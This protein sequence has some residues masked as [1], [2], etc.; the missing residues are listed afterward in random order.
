MPS[1]PPSCPPPTLYWCFTHR[2]LH[3][4]Q[5]LGSRERQRMLP[6]N[7]PS[8][9]PAS[10]SSVIVFGLLP[11]TWHPTLKAVPRTSF[12]VPFSSLEKDLYR[13]VLAISTISSRV[14][15]LLCLMFFSFFR[16][17]GGSFNAL[18]MRDDAVGTTET[19]ACRFWI[20]N[21]TVTRSPFCASHLVSRRPERGSRKSPSIPSRPSPSRY[22][23][24]LSSAT[25]REDRSWGREPTT[26]QPHRQ[27]LGGDCSQ[28]SVSSVCNDGHMTARW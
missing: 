26:H 24:P 4:S 3:A 16:S 10:M 8:S 21:L 12:T 7:L 6:W 2:E 17:R 23:H 5:S 9:S 25:D 18:M 14:T 27:W 1:K 28:A 20:V 22:L 13:I 11:S 15:D 19:A